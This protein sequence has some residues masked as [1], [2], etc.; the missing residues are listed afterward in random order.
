LAI[1]YL[2]SKF[3]SRVQILSIEGWAITKTPPLNVDSMDFL[4]KF[5]KASQTLG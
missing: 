4:P 1:I 5:L 2:A 3:V